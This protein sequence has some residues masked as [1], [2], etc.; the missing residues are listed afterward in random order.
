MNVHQI[1]GKK[2][3]QQV[4]FFP[5]MADD[6]PITLPVINDMTLIIRKKVTN[7]CHLL[8]SLNSF[9]YVSDFQGASKILQQDIKETSS[10]TFNYMAG[11]E[12]VNIVDCLKT[13]VPK[14]QQSLAKVNAL[15]QTVLVHHHDQAQAP[16]WYDKFQEEYQTTNELL[17]ETESGLDV[18]EDLYMELAVIFRR[19][20][21][22]EKSQVELVEML[23]TAEREK[24]TTKRANERDQTQQRQQRLLCE[25]LGNLQLISAS[26]EISKIDHRFCVNTS[27]QDYHNCLA[28]YKRTVGDRSLKQQK[29][30]LVREKCRLEDLYRNLYEVKNQILKQ[31]L[32]V[33]AIQEL[34][35]QKEKKKQ[36]D[37]EKDRMLN[38]ISL[39]KAQLDEYAKGLRKGIRQM[40]TII[41]GFFFVCLCF[42]FVWVL[43]GFLSS[44]FG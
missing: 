30:R 22:Q 36:D 31:L 28:H 5:A 43:V 35:D 18:I 1:V 40:K 41:K 39:R 16:L 15:V 29:E 10:F 33:H 14:F 23:V 34:V 37:E 19:Q 3:R 26:E 6:T 17:S 11:P 12:F 24:E 13:L 7:A 32:V 25:E 4:C 8:A 21:L 20:N 44:S 9:Q 38:Q 2:G 27:S 42:L